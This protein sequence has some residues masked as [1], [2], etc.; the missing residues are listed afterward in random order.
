MDASVLVVAIASL[1]YVASLALMNMP[2]KELKVWGRSALMHSITGIAL[3]SIIPALIF[4]RDLI[5]PYVEPYIGV[6]I[7]V[8]PETALAHVKQYQSM[9]MEWIN[10]IN[11]SALAIGAMQAI[12]MLA[13]TPLLITGVGVLFATI[14]SYLFSSVFGGLIFAQKFFSALY[15][16]SEIIKV[17]ISLV[18]VVGPG[19]F[20]IGLILFATPFA[21][22]LGKT[23]IVL[24]A[25]LTLILP[26]VVVATLPGPE[27]AEEEL[28]KTR[29]IQAYSIALGK[30]RE[31]NTGVKINIF[32]RNGTIQHIH[33]GREKH[34]SRMVKYP[35]FKLEMQGR[36]GAPPLLIDCS[37][38]PPGVSCEMVAKAVLEMLEQP[39]SG[40][41]NSDQEKIEE[42]YRTT[43]TTVEMAGVGKRAGIFKPDTWLLGLW[44]YMQGD[45]GK[46]DEPVRIVG[47]Q[48]KTDIPENKKLECNDITCW[49][50]ENDIY[51]EWK[52]R[53]EKFWNEAPS[54]KL[55]LEN[56]VQEGEKTSLIWFTKRPVGSD[57]PLN[58]F[59]VYPGVQ[60]LDCRIVG[61][62]QEGNETKYRY[63]VFVKVS[64]A[65]I[66]Y[67][68][69]LE[70]AEYSVES[71]MPI[72]IREVNASELVGRVVKGAEPLNLKP[73]I[74]GYGDN[75]PPDLEAS[76]P[77]HYMLVYFKGGEFQMGEGDSCEEA[78]KQYLEEMVND[79]MLEDNSTNPYVDNYRE[80]YE[81]ET[82]KIEQY[83]NSTNNESG[84]F[85]GTEIIP[86]PDETNSTSTQI[87]LPPCVE[88]GAVMPISVT[89][90]FNLIEESPIAPWK[91][92]VEWEKFEM[93]EE[94]MKEMA[95]GGYVSE[96][97]I[98]SMTKIDVKTHREEWNKYPTF[99]LGLYR[100]GPV[101]YGQRLVVDKLMEYKTMNW[102]KSPIAKMVYET[103]KNVAAKAKMSVPGGG[104]PIP[105]ID[106]LV[107]GDKGITLIDAL[108]KLLGHTVAL[109]FALLVFMVAVD[110]ISGMIG[111]QSAM[112]TVMASPIAALYK[113]FYHGGTFASAG[114][115]ASKVSI[116]EY[117]VGKK[118]ERE[119]LKSAHKERE[120][121][122]L[123]W[124]EAQ[125]RRI[126]SMRFY[127]R[128]IE[129]IRSRIGEKLLDM[130]DRFE[131]KGIAGKVGSFV[132]DE[133][134]KKHA[135]ATYGYLLRT[136]PSIASRHLDQA[137]YVSQMRPTAMTPEKWAQGMAQMIKTAPTRLEKIALID[138]IA[139]DTSMG[140]NILIKDAFGGLAEEVSWLT[141]GR[142][143]IPIS[144]EI[145]APAAFAIATENAS[146]PLLDELGGSRPDIPHATTTSFG[147]GLVTRGLEHVEV[148]YIH[149]GQDP[150]TTFREIHE[151]ISFYDTYS[152]PLSPEEKTELS[153]T[154]TNIHI[155]QP[156]LDDEMTGGKHVEVAVRPPDSRLEP[157]WI[158][159]EK[160]DSL[161][162]ILRDNV[163]AARVVEDRY[164]AG[165]THE[166]MLYKG[167]D[168]GPQLPEDVQKAFPWASG[169]AIDRLGLEGYSV[170][171]I[172]GWWETGGEQSSSPT[173][174]TEPKLDKSKTGGWWNE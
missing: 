93:D 103:F 145:K 60:S 58:V 54:K 52:A 53:W 37:T 91:P 8:G 128:P 110:T 4:V 25:A 134:S 65:P 113:A 139:R 10:A 123:K 155:D 82:S 130:R 169:D 44:M 20:T 96:E 62:H 152:R 75:P 72:D 115:R 63:G 116:A 29:E 42:G 148:P 87:G 95:S 88:S 30:V 66:T 170:G 112:K 32:D 159:S 11:L 26:P 12:L 57:Q 7:S 141:G 69:Y 100:D 50:E 76:P 107:S 147:I 168:Y 14:A 5:A 51:E 119:M 174:E 21:R 47:K 172:P 120:R 111:G 143:N 127:R 36:E 94:Y 126:A 15:L 154:L 131:D 56:A 125:E 146:K 137:R 108:A 161:P 3:F 41:I 43:L 153:Q 33:G 97:A 22:K 136:E 89:V 144:R 46:R 24:G 34:E 86:E 163:V 122:I 28:R 35:Y 117:I 129:R 27:E 90:E 101:H 77:A 140:R 71:D 73:S 164:E 150:Y 74:P 167:H 31:I 104:V 105:T 2:L 83:L 68:T 149:R 19:M 99:R 39:E 80:C 9:I 84:N 158:D 61:S 67:F 79:L 114:R 64:P 142:I 165:E 173:G 118:R 49:W 109:A 70:G 48:I 85:T 135:L 138:K 13:L 162:S 40:F 133:L 78:Y 23:L 16:F 38:L 156:R 121:N 102:E 98:E 132:L 106:V 171:S 55:Y 18:P 59:V 151:S 157:F 81:D 45:T 160:L 1:V 92:N 17:F 166:G 6:D 124:K